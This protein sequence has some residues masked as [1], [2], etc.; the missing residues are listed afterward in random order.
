MTL[1]DVLVQAYIKNGILA[2]GEPLAAELGDTGLNDANILLEEWNITPSVM[3]WTTDILAFP[4]TPLVLPI[5]YYTIGPSGADF[6]TARP[7][8][9]LRANVLITSSTPQIR[10]PIQVVEDMEWSDVS[11]PDLQTAPYPTKIYNDGGFPN[12]RIYTWPV[13]NAAGN[14]MEL[15]IPHQVSAF[16]AVT[17][18]FSFP[19]GFLGAFMYTL[20]ERLCEGKREIPAT[21]MRSAARARNAWGRINRQSPKMGTT[22]SG[23]PNNGRGDGPGNTWYN[24]W[25]SR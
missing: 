24:G 9:I 19:N 20:S 23:M 15:F 25:M 22:D 18:T 16:A 17:D 1:S 12:S 13:P 14:S 3:I 10:I 8:K 2:D 7:E 11:T 5:T 4:M 6:I 21:L